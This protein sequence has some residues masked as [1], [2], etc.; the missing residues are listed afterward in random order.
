MNSFLQHYTGHLVLYVELET[1]CFSKYFCHMFK[2]NYAGILDLS[3]GIYKMTCGRSMNFF[4]EIIN[5]NRNFKLNIYTYLI[6]FHFDAFTQ[7]SERCFA[8]GSVKKK[9]KEKLI[10]NRFRIVKIW[11]LFLLDPS[12]CKNKC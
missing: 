6:N 5:K 1:L 11:F 4:L 12:Q 9:E 7:L 10:I 8:A 2:W 3:L